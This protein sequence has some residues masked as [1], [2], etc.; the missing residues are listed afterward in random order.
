MDD[1]YL[2]SWSR[3]VGFDRA[4]GIYDDHPTENSY[5]EQDYVEMNPSLHEEDAP[6]KLAAVAS[7]LGQAVP[8]NEID[9]IADFG[10]GRCIVTARSIDLARSATSHEVHGIAIDVSRRILGRSID[11]PNLIKLRATCEDV[12]LETGSI[13]LALC[14]DIVE[15]VSNP[16]L[17]VR[18]VARVSRYCV[19]KIPI[20]RCLYT[21]LRGGRRRL[22]RLRTKLGHVHHFSRRGARDL[23]A[24][25]LTILNEA[26]QPIP[27]RGPVLDYVQRV[28]LDLGLRRTFAATFGGFI[29]LM[30]RS[31]R[32]AGPQQP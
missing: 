16:E 18:E 4:L 23:V 1:A 29:V 7:C 15:H 28:L 9:T 6:A 30:A 32:H 12:P 11:H 31:N 24:S 21:Q 14:M 2:P 17:L 20:E 3:P 10:A 19:F 22:A 5:Y 13:S 8:L 25:E 26:F 27:R